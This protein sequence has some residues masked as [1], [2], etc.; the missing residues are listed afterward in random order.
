MQ[1]SKNN[2]PE[3]FVVKLCLL[4]TVAGVLAL[5]HYGICHFQQILRK[6]KIAEK[7]AALGDS[8]QQASQD[9][10]AIKAQLASYGVGKAPSEKPRNSDFSRLCEWLYN[11][12]GLPI[13][14][15]AVNFLA[16]GNILINGVIATPSLSQGRDYLQMYRS[17]LLATC[18]EPYTCKI[19][20]DVAVADSLPDQKR[21]CLTVALVS[22]P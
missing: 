1:E 6:S 18:P 21:F 12:Q 20:A 5:G 8:Y 19:N 10:A 11:T 17:K 9:L 3:R 2:P 7:E 14:F 15:T 22:S 13:G 4:A 16:E